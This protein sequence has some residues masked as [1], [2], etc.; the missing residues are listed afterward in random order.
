MTQAGQLGTRPDRSQ[1]EARLALAIFFDR[2]AR[3][4]T[5]ATINLQRP[6]LEP[7]E[8]GQGDRRAAKAVGLN[9]VRPGLEIAAVDFMDDVGTRQVQDLRAILLPPIVA[10][11]IQI[12]RLNPAASAAVAEQDAFGQGV[13]KFSQDIDPAWIWNSQ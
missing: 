5:G 12:H 7:V 10:L 2:L 9:D 1:D 8:F 11:D 6:V 4:F 13:K 3:Q